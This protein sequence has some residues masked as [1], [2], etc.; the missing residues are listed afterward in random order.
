[1]QVQ[2]LRALE[3]GYRDIKHFYATDNENN[4][5]RRCYVPLHLMNNAVIYYHCRLTVVM[6]VTSSDRPIII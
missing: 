6:A 4:Y 3:P 2:T 5:K 1:M